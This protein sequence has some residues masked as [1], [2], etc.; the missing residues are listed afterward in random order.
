M[1][2]LL[3]VDVNRT[4]GRTF[5]LGGALAAAAGFVVATYFGGVN[6][7]MGH[8]L[9]FKALAAAIIGGIGSVGGAILGGLLIGLFETLWSGYLTVAYKDIAVFAA[10]TLVLIWRPGG[11]LG[12]G[13][14]RRV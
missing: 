8:M 13:P 5:M 1:A 9:G 11:L 14:R 4:I 10:L 6:F 2:A 7:F 3:G 12:G